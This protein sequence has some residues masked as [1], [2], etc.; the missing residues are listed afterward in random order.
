[1]VGDAAPG[2]P[3]PNS[4]PSI[5]WSSDTETDRDRNTVREREIINHVTRKDSPFF[6]RK[7]SRIS[8]EL[9]TVAQ[10]Q[11]SHECLGLKNLN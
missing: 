3:K 1:M 11:A 5:D 8:E 4:P 2:L 6:T 9:K 10:R 7:N